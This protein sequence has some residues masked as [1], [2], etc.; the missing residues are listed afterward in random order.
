MTVPRYLGQDHLVAS[1]AKAK[2]PPWIGTDGNRDSLIKGH[3]SSLVPEPFS[4]V[5]AALGAS[6]HCAGGSQ[7]AP[8]GLRALKWP[9]ELKP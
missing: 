5:S 3:Q 2:V 8:F 6:N 7:M 1:P 4:P 9:L